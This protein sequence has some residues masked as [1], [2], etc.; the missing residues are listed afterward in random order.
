[1]TYAGNPD[2]L[3]DIEENKNYE[4][5]KGDVCDKNVVKS[6]MKGCDMVLNFAAETHV[7]RSIGTP[8]DFINTD[9]FGTYV[10]L[11]AARNFKIKK[12]IQ[13]STDEVYGS[14]ETGSFEETDVLNPSSPYAASK[15]AA[16]LLV[17][18]YFVTYGVPTL[19]T[20]S[21][22]NFGYYQYPEKLIPL[23][24]T[25]IIKS[26]KVPLYGDGL[27]IRDWIYVLDNCDAIDFI[28]HNGILGEIYNIGAGNEKTN[29][30]ITK[31]ILTELGKDESSIEYVKDRVGHDRRYAL[32][33]QKLNKL[34]WKPK[35][36]F[37]E[38]LKETIDWYKENK[39]WWEKIKSGDY[40]EYYKKHYK[41]RHGMKG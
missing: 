23:F 20:R 36:K 22:N 28:L 4:F 33:C 34:G 8:E 32:N 40:L 31:T 5:V 39:G 21:S 37:E 1:M 26:K 12:F 41:E 15:A 35:F 38:A 3:K 30:K 10:L 27:N 13:I 25:N 7:D 14:I 18:S 6:A 11:E 17:N 19:I 29:I 24:I 2:N 16:D 9:V